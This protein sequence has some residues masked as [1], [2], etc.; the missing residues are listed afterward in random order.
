MGSEMCIRDRLETL[1]KTIC[2]SGAIACTIWCF[3]EYS[4]NE[5]MCE[6]YFK[7]F[8]E[9]EESVY[10]ELT[11]GFPHQLNETK[12]QMKFGKDMNSSIFRKHLEGKLWDDRILDTSLKDVNLNFGNYYL[13]NCIW[14]SPFQ[15][16]T[17]LKPVN[18]IYLFGMEYHTFRFPS[19]SPVISSWFQFRTS[20][21]SNGINPS[22]YELI[23]AFQYPNQIQERKRMH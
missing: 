1:F 2:I 4:K 7:S 22:I 20:V 15:P 13:S 6:V 5:D 12:L 3:Y 19:G 11:I 17:K 23:I 10:P 21:F 16:C 9:D 14:S 18:T 8:L